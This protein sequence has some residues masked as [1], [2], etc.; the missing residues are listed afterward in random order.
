M[1]ES[2]WECGIS[3]TIFCSF[4]LYWCCFLLWLP[5]HHHQITPHMWLKCILW[6]SSVQVHTSTTFHRCSHSEK[7]VG[8]LAETATRCVSHY[9]AGSPLNEH[10][11]VSLHMLT[12]WL[13]IEWRQSERKICSAS[14]IFASH[15]WVKNADVKQPSSSWHKRTHVHMCTQMTVEAKMFHNNYIHNSPILKAPPSYLSFCLDRQWS[16]VFLTATVYGLQCNTSR[17]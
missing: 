16:W 15:P 3:K 7:N 8:A 10:P 5:H 11:S 9:R 2:V 17:N 4:Q 14:F 12:W 6:T 1:K 13:A